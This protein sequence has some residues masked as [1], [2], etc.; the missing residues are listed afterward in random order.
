M[1][2]LTGEGMKPTEDA[3]PLRAGGRARACAV[4]ADV[5]VFYRFIEAVARGATPSVVVQ[6]LAQGVRGA[7]SRAG[8]RRRVARER[9]RGSALPVPR[10][11]VV[12]RAARGRRRAR[13]LRRRAVVGPPRRWA[14]S[15]AGNARRPRRGGPHR[16][17]LARRRCEVAARCRAGPRWSGAPSRRRRHFTLM[18]P[19]RSPAVRAAR[20]SRAVPLRRATPPGRPRTRARSV[21]RP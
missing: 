7:R 1:R 10:R 6:H 13:D 9:A 2:D 17:V 11:R 4:E 16:G 5:A 19:V 14:R 12:H 21:G 8:P 3:E 18:R 15:G 20:P